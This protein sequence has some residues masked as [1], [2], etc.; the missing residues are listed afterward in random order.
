MRA[1]LSNEKSYFS[2]KRVTEVVA[3]ASVIL[4]Y[5]AFIIANIRTLTAT[6]FVIAS[7]PILAIAGYVLNHTQKEKKS[8]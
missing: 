2:K 6:E 3:F 8:E 7:A 1:L 5:L 4:T